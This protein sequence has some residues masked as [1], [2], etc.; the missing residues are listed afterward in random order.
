M[1]AHLATVICSLHCDTAV[2]LTLGTSLAQS[3]LLAGLTECYS[4]FIECVLVYFHIIISEVRYMIWCRK[5]ARALAFSHQIA[6]GCVLYNFIFSFAFFHSPVS[7]RFC[8]RAVSTQYTH[9]PRI[10][11]DSVGFF[12]RTVSYL[13][14]SFKCLLNALKRIKSN[15]TNIIYDKVKRIEESSK[16]QNQNYCTFRSCA[17]AL[18]MSEQF[19]L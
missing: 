16:S 3:I 15:C 17:W 6:G 18:K 14:V 4:K 8:H 9:T 10:D 7:F 5:Q 19:R 1:L 12:K 13:S 2:V 11:L